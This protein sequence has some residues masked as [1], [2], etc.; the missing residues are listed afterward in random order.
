[1]ITGDVPAN[2][3][4]D[5]LHSRGWVRFPADPVLRDWV[6]RVREP[7]L[8]QSEREDSRSQWLRCGGTWFAGV[9]ALP[10]EPDGAIP[11]AGVPA[12][13][14][15][16]VRAVAAMLGGVSIKWDRAQVSI[17]YPGYPRHSGEESRAAFDYR[18]RR[19]AAHV[20]GFARSDPG[21]RRK[22]SETHGFVLGIPLT[23]TDPA[24]SPLSVWEG[25]HRILRETLRRA[26]AG[27]APEDWRSID[28]TDAYIAARRSCFERCRRV[29]VSAS[30]GEAYLVHRLA[31]HGITPWKAPAD[32]P[33]RAVAYFRPD[34]F[35]G[36]SP[37]WWLT[38]P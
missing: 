30:P 37:E 7:A 4:L 32:A 35:P 24:A 3:A 31:L 17:C 22:L 23:A 28:I 36:Q 12:L 18:L 21:R 14:G 6:E 16:A 25:S 34:P 5:R 13:A 15:E 9:N 2:P 29:S 19:H 20:D 33:P 1:M 11:E 10:N 27:V 8:A 38:A 26:Y